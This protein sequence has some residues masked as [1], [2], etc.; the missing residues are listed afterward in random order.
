MK[1]FPLWAIENTV[2]PGDIRRDDYFGRA[3]YGVTCAAVCLD[4]QADAF[5]LFA[6]LGILAG[7]G[8]DTDDEDDLAHLLENLIGSARTDSM[9]H[10][11]VVYFPGWQFA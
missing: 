11:I 3:M 6:Q 5:R 8:S 2:D 10:G 4:S 7:N 1:V 9:G